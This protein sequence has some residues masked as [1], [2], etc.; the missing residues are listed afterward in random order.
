VQGLEE[1]N[2]RMTISNNLKLE[3]LAALSALRR[4]GGGLVVRLNT[5]HSG[6]QNTCTHARILH[7]DQHYAEKIKSI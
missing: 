5:V 4:V 3:S 7:V 6:A 2:W 1:V